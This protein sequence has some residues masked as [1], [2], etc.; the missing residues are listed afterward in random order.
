MS[1]IY[2]NNANSIYGVV[3]SV[4]VRDNGGNHGAY[5]DCD[6]A[7]DRIKAMCLD[8]AYGNAIAS[9]ISEACGDIAWFVSRIDN[10]TVSLSSLVYYMD[11]D[12]NKIIKCGFRISIDFETNAGQQLALISKNWHD[13]TINDI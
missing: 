11:N 1:V 6:V 13:S 2:L 10:D 9:D 3:K 4:T 7:R 5:Y 8:N 12:E